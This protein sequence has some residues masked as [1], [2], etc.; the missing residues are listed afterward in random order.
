MFLFV[1][2]GNTENLVNDQGLM[3][4]EDQSMGSQKVQVIWSIVNSVII[5]TQGILLYLLNQM[6]SGIEQRALIK[7]IY[8]AQQNNEGLRSEKTRPDKQKLIIMEPIDEEKGIEVLKNEMFDKPVS[9]KA[10]DLN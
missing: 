6:K 9:Q 8:C 5:L 3:V 2:I 10:S 7:A 4:D 1:G